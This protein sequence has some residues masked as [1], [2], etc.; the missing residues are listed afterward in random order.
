MHAPGGIFLKKIGL[1]LPQKK[2]KQ[3]GFREV[4]SFNRDEYLVLPALVARPSMVTSGARPILVRAPAA[5]G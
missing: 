3:L 1:R 5:P 2:L 4:S